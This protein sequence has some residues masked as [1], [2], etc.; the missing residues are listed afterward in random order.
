MC[1]SEKTSFDHRCAGKSP[2][3]LLVPWHPRKQAGRSLLIGAPPPAVALGGGG[4][5]LEA[6]TWWGAGGGVTTSKLWKPVLSQE[7]PGRPGCDSNGWRDV[8]MP[9]VKDEAP[10]LPRLVSQ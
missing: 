1:P 6:N 2:R 5:S 8:H 9:P 3:G 10:L 7:E 4:D